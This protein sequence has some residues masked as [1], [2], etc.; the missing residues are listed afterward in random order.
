[1]SFIFAGDVNTRICD[2]KD[3]ACYSSAV[4]R[5]R[6][7]RTGNLTVATFREK[8]DCLPSCADIRYSTEITDLKYVPIDKK[9]S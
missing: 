9:R 8:C 2:V 3:L 4:N 7:G 5:H 6:I 1:M